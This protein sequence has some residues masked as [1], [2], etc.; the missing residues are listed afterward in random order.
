MLRM[1]HFIVLGLL[2][3]SCTLVSCVNI[4]QARADLARGGRAVCPYCW[5]CA[6][7]WK[8][9][10]PCRPSYRDLCP[11]CAY[12][13]HCSSTCV[14]LCRTPETPAP[15]PPPTTTPEP[16]PPPTTT[17]EPTP[18]TAPRPTTPA[19][20]PCLPNPCPLNGNC[21]AIENSAGYTCSCPENVDP[22]N[23]DVMDIFKRYNYDRNGPSF[24]EVMLE[25]PLETPV[26]GAIYQFTLNELRYFSDIPGIHN[27]MQDAARH[28]LTNYRWTRTYGADIAKQFGD[29]HER[30]NPNPFNE[31]AM[32]LHNNARGRELALDAA[33]TNRDALEV[34]REAL[35]D[36]TLQVRP[37]PNHPF[38]QDT[39]SNPSYNE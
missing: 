24:N 35:M 6:H 26:V 20:N 38:N 15:T 33:N 29:A 9:G 11:L 23:D 36:G 28:A 19:T 14:N 4:A 32:D 3:L 34:I 17:P 1:V 39:V 25:N 12:R 7:E 37:N 22:C 27:G 21:H 2:C 30:S 16:T 31:L 8:C 10:Q 13:F 5:A 18:T